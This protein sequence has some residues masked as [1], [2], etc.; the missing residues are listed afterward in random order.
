[1]TR[2]TLLLVPLF[3][4]SVAAVHASIATE[5][6][7]MKKL[8]DGQTTPF[9]AD[10]TVSKAQ[11]TTVAVTD[12]RAERMHNPMSLD[13]PTPRLGWRISSTT[14]D[15]MQTSCH[16]IVASTEDKALNCEGDLWDTTLE[17]NQSQWIEYA[18]ERLKS[19]TRC[20][21]RVKI[22]TTKGSSEWSDVAVFNVGLLTES[23]W[24]G[25]WIGLDRA[26]A[27]EKEDV[28]SQLGARYL[29]SEFESEGTIRRATLYISGLGLYEAYINGNRIGDR[30]LTPAPTDYRKTVL[31]DAY[32]V[33]E[34]IQSANAIA[35]AVGNGRYY[36]MQQNKKPYKIN[37]FGYPKLRLNLIIEYEDGSK[38]KIVTNNK[39]KLNA[40]GPI[41]SNNEYDGEIYD[42]QKQ[43]DGWTLPGFDD[44]AW[45][46]AERVAIP[47]GTLHGSM[48]PGMTVLKTIEPQSI[49]NHDDTLIIDFGQ[50]L[51]GRVKLRVR[52]V[53]KGDTVRIRFA[54]KT[55]SDG[56]LWRDNFRN[57]LSTDYYVAA[58]NEDGTW[59]AP[60]F[61]YHGFR[62]AEITGMPTATAHDFIA[63]VIS[64]EM[65][66]TGTFV[67]S[68]TILNKVFN[69]ARWGVLANYKGM[70][71][72]CPQRD[73]RQPWLGDRTRGCFGEAFL[74]N[75]NALYAKWARDIT[76]AQRSDGCIPDVAPAFWNYYS[77]NVTWPAALPFSM[78]M[79]YMHY[80]DDAPIRNYYDNVKQ[81]LDHLTTQYA[82]DGIMPRDK[83]GDWCVPPEEPSMIHSRDSSRQT[84][85][86][87]IAT[88]YY[89]GIT[90]MMSRFARL[91][92]KTDD[93]RTW[94]EQ[95]ALI[96]RAFNE[97]FLTYKPGTSLVPGHWLYPDSTFYGN[98]T[99]TAN[100]LPLAFGIADTAS[101][102]RQEL[103][104]NIIRNIITLNK[105]QIS[106]GVIGVGWLMHALND[107][108]RND[109]AWLLAT[110]KK[111]PGWGY[112]TEK[113]ATTIWELWNGDTAAP[114][115]NSGN[116][117]MLLGD[118]LSWLYEDIA[119][120]AADS[121]E[122][123]FKHIVMRPDF[124]VDEIDSIDAAYMSIYGRVVSRWTKARGTLTWHVEI[125]A[126]TTATLY[127]PNGKSETVGSGT[128]DFT[129][130]LP[131]RSPAV[132]TDEFLYTKASF[133]EC[134]SSTI[135][136]TAEGDL[137]A[138]YFGG[139]KERNPDVCIWVQRK[140]K[141]TDTWTAPQMVA[142]GVLSDTL[143]KACWNPVVYQLPGGDLRIY[144]KIGK[145][146][147][148]WTGWQVSSTDGGRSWSPRTQ[149]QD[150]FLGPVKN[151]PVMNEGRLIAPASVEKGGW[152]LYFEYSD[153]KGL[154]WQKTDFVEADSG[155]LA[156][157]PAIL[158]LPDGRLQAVARTRNRHI[159]TTYSDDNGETWSRLQLIETPNNNSGIDALT[160]R[161]G[162]YAMI[163]NDWPLEP[164]IVKG[165]RTPLSLLLS[166]DGLNWRR[167]LTVED[168]PVSQYSYPSMI[169][170][171]DG[172]IHLIYTWR[173]Q[174]IKH[175]V[176]DP[177]KL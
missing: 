41:R 10:K 102:I 153:D 120:I 171:E 149:L 44:S 173:R 164:G 76:D 158:V 74:Y 93:A 66:E 3:I 141:G 108:G 115:M 155:V 128:H 49:A 80:G 4:T 110:N 142:D 19:D 111:Y 134:H 147:A 68:D 169:Q 64:D 89:Y 12:L 62:F 40:D 69:N 174:R 78:E 29:R 2:R 159:V 23:D 5:A 43:F 94:D 1:M 170:T 101:S 162:R 100:L 156:I 95:A 118:L 60:T 123:G 177:S 34:L 47:Y 154:S 97:R 18:G 172:N 37:N 121:I 83:Y 86:T 63:E 88:A 38:K 131:T 35:V 57:A 72:D 157:Q 52:N 140:E 30:V 103:E 138:T 9:V 90:K 42:A 22:T 36:T 28:H 11:S 119:G 81:W 13:T 54:E 148:D 160:L 24:G 67:C 33:T 17:T 73:E 75:N 32:D 55:N 145:N 84:D 56:S 163:C 7:V 165:P 135:A 92:E 59:W 125:P 82:R 132:I 124:G 136:E 109:V 21:W 99:V 51:A 27:W 48:S 87:L 79:M 26:M 15:V 50:N 98:N 114:A 139:T 146:V 25:Q 77:D 107:M 143:R 85:G 161:D 168:S 152:R 167:V 166:D 176:I 6:K 8:A 137:V 16:I 151:K 133:P 58:G 144:F 117:V 113:G 14:D 31:Y 112:M 96:R 65:E 116:H 150:G 126:N 105:G 70:P 39:W 175:V 130:T 46:N 61:V 71:V 104:K 122:P 91:L 127:F 53:A 106:C 20:Y 45:M 129:V